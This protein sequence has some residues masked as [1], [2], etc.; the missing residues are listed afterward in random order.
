MVGDG[1][2]PNIFF[3]TDEGNVVMVT[4]DFDAAYAHWRKLAGRAPRIESALE[5]RRWGT[6]ASV[7]PESDDPGARLI[8]IDD[9][10]EF[11]REAE[12]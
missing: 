12:R 3:V 1:R 5:D 9:S 11:L 8:I 6:V 10:G 2:R 4:L 7:E